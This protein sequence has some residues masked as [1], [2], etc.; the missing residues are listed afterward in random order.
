LHRNYHR[1][2]TARQAFGLQLIH[3][4]S[5]RTVLV[6]NVPAHLRGDRAL[7]EYFEGCG[8]QVESVSVV[9]QVDAVKSALDKRTDA[10]LRLEEAWVSWVG[11]PARADG[12]DPNMYH[13]TS[14]AV[15]PAV[16]PP[17][18]VSPLE[19]VTHDDPES[20]RQRFSSIQTAKPRP[21]KRIGLR[22]VDA[23]EY[24][25]NQFLEADHEVQTLRQTGRFRPTHVAFVS[26]EDVKS[27][28]AAVQVVHYREHSKVVTTTAPEPRDVIW[29]KLA[30]S[31]RERGIRSIIVMALMVV[32]LTTWICKVHIPNC[33]NLQSPLPRSPRCCRTRRSREFCPGSPN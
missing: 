32:L 27:A 21:T 29:G 6:T 31:P 14:K 11:N 17:V 7:A 28:Q 20:I 1:F 24:W 19:Q 4:V 3:S 25:E 10:L 8:W 9:R 26:F 23:I 30:I 22:K 33:A 5:A 12:Y 13:N 15:S 16:E 2:V 18:S